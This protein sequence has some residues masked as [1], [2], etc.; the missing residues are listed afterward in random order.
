[1]IIGKPI[2]ESHELEKSMELMCVSIGESA[3]SRAKGGMT[4]RLLD[5]NL[6]IEYEI[7]IIERVGKR[8]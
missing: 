7:P 5:S 4:N 1:M 2:V 6:L 8:V 3:Q